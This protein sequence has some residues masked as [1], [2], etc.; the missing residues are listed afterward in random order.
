MKNDEKHWNGLEQMKQAKRERRLKLAKLP[1]EEKIQ[2]LLKL[3][4]IA[5]AM[6]VSKKR[7][8]RVWEL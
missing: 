4:E 2:I 1:L 6:P 3:Q 8:R 5:S 7:N